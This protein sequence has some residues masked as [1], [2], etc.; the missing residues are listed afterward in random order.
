[1]YVSGSVI[2][3]AEGEW[4]CD[5]LV[6]SLRPPPPFLRGGHRCQHRHCRCSKRPSQRGPLPPPGRALR[7][8]PGAASLCPTSPSSWSVF[9]QTDPWASCMS[10][11]WCLLNH[12]HVWAHPRQS[13]SLG[14][15]QKI[16][17]CKPAPPAVRLPTEV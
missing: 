13:E 10:I 8:P 7:P 4:S 15:R 2:Y 1:M 5:C 9:P 6:P 16:C 3:F 11:F 17:V 12:G 14:E